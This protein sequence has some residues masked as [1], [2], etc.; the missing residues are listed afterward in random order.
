[1]GK[2]YQL[3]NPSDARI[4]IDL[5]K[6]KVKFEY[7]D[8]QKPFKIVFQTL[9][10]IWGLFLILVLILIILI[11]LSFLIFNLI[12][13]EKVE[14]CELNLEKDL[15]KT[16]NI[17]KENKFIEFG[18]ENSET[19]IGVTLALLITVLVFLVPPFLTSLI[20]MKSEKLMK[21]IPNI[22]L[23]VEKLM[24]RGNYYKKVTKLDK[25]FFEIQVFDNVFLDYNSTGDFRKYLEKLEIIEHDMFYEK[26]SLFKKKKKVKQTDFWSAKFYF[27]KT[28][29]KGFMELRW[30]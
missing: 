14:S 12:T 11:L 9:K 8:K 20:F 27:K 1:M 19:T 5:K 4:K 3:N 26:E 17:T 24:G 2:K 18:E 21:K 7:P 30:I 25:P 10:G 29:T 13:V 22:N 6:N 28:P 15:G 23:W 16:S